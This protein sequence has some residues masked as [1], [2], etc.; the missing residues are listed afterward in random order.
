[1]RRANEKKE[2]MNLYSRTAVGTAI[3]DLG[4]SI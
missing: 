4:M 3:L 2:D 1:M